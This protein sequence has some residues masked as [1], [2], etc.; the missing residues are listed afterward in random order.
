LPKSAAQIRQ[1][2]DLSIEKQIKEG[3]IVR[4]VL[5]EQQ[6]YALC[7]DFRYGLNYFLCYIASSF[8]YIYRENNVSIPELATKY[9]I[10]EK[11]IQII[12]AHIRS[13]ILTKDKDEPELFIAS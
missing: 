10:D 13:P 8:V 1:E 2:R 4:N 6:L 9:N 12:L 5:D 3:Q 11:I 7:K